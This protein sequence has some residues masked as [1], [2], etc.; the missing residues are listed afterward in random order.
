MGKAIKILVSLGILAAI[1]A[2]DLS[3]NAIAF[4]PGI[5]PISET[6]TEAVLE[7]AQLGVTAV[8]LFLTREGE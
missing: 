8:I 5:G 1:A 3:L 4:L 6:T 2:V 7:I